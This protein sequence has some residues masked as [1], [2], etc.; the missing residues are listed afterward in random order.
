M[1]SFLPMQNINLTQKLL[2]IKKKVM[3][4]ESN[5]YEHLEGI[6]KKSLKC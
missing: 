4:W 6:F 5:L 1:A 2:S 3:F